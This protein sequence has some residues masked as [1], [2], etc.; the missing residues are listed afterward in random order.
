MSSSHAGWSRRVASS[1]PLRPFFNR[2]HLN[3]GVAALNFV[4]IDVHKQPIPPRLHEMEDESFLPIQKSKPDH[5]AVE[6]VGS[7][8]YVQGH[9]VPESLSPRRP[10]VGRA[11][12]ASTASA[13]VGFRPAREL[14]VRLQSCVTV[15]FVDPDADVRFVSVVLDEIAVE[16]NGRT[17]DG[18]VM[19][20]E[21][22]LIDRHSIAVE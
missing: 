3:Q 12:R 16:K 4:A 20:D 18:K 2:S 6:E 22:G 13:A 11:K 17:I 10:L 15:V 1:K 14:L 21:I 5:V 19:V 7:W 9:P 8:P